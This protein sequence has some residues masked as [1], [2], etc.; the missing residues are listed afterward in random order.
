MASPTVNALN[1]EP[2][3]MRVGT[4]DVFF[5]TTTQTDAATGRILQTTVEPQA[6][7]EGVVLSV[8]PQICERRDDQ[9][10]HHAQ[11]DRAHGAGDV[12]LRRHG[13]D[14]Q[15]ARSR[16]AGARARERNDRHC[17]IDGGT[18]RPST[19]RC[20]F[21]AIYRASARIFRS[22][23]TSRRKTDLVILLTPRVM[24]PARIAESAA[25]EL[26]RVSTR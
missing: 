14:S 22:E 9:H 10:E 2:V 24:T 11:P 12:A 4:Q 18:V 1:N 7:T 19:R 23:T 25:K 21:S 6:I 20:R 3:I 15:R 17:G 13:A 8:T 26:E 16:H 5:K